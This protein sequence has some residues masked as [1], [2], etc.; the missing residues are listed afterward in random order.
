[1]ERNLE[2]NSEMLSTFTAWGGKG[3]KGGELAKHDIDVMNTGKK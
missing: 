3:G 2:E 1:M